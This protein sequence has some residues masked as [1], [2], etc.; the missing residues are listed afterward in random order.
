MATTYPY[1]TH[2]HHTSTTLQFLF[3]YS[4]QCYHL[5]HLQGIQVEPGVSHVPPSTPR[6]SSLIEDA[7]IDI[8]FG[9]SETYL[10]C[11]VS[12]NSESMLRNATSRVRTATRNIFL[13]RQRPTSPPKP[14]AWR[15]ASTAARQSRLVSTSNTRLQHS[16]SHAPTLGVRD[17]TIYA[18][19]TA[20]GRA[21]IAIV[22]ISGPSCMDVCRP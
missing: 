12:S 22:R 4:V 9:D 2:Y 15:W 14:R 5:D 17:D 8:K 20:P 19:S 21:G 16:Q 1:C 10:G 3:H 6:I 13:H 18:V 11:L 7:L